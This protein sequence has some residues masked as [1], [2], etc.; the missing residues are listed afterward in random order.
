MSETQLTPQL[1]TTEVMIENALVALQ[2]VSLAPGETRADVAIAALTVKYSGLTITDP[3]DRKQVKVV[4]D[5]RIDVK[6]VRN[7][8][9][10]KRKTIKADALRYS[11]AIDEEANRLKA[12]LLPLEGAL[13][14]EEDKVEEYKARKA[15]EERVA[16]KAK[17][18][19]RMQRLQAI[20]VNTIPSFVE[21]LDDA[22]FEEMHEQARLAFEEARAR[23]ELE[24]AEAA[25]KAAE[26]EKARREERERL[27]RER[28]EL[29][30]Q[31]RQQAAKQAELD[32]Q[33]R[34][35]L[36][37]ENEE[38]LLQKAKEDEEQR[39]RDIQAAKEQGEREERARVLAEQEHAE[40]QKEADAAKERRRI[41]RLP[42]TKKL[43]TIAATIEALATLGLPEALDTE[44]RALLAS[45]AQAVREIA[46]REE[47]A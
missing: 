28:A 30:E 3:T 43:R 24:R 41:A 5:A 19:S 6:G 46:E 22:K 18:D 20:G 38:A 8:L 26:E 27:D 42:I 13:Q 32:E 47:R 33:E 17:L 14:F 11:Q 21:G 15:E 36:E 40:K 39:A 2:P 16:A 4:H 9:E 45:A 29:D 37:R 35:R 31:K 25:R 7:E 44:V 12:M 10:R 34:K 23:A 1:I